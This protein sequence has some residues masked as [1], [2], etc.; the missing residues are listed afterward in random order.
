MPHT[1]ARRPPRVPRA[2]RDNTGNIPDTFMDS[3]TPMAPL[4]TNHAASR[5]PRAHSTQPVDGQQGSRTRPENVPQSAPKWHVFRSSRRLSVP[6]C[7][8]AGRA[9]SRRRSARGSR[10]AGIGSRGRRRRSRVHNYAGNVPSVIPARS[11]APDGPWVPIQ[12][13]SFFLFQIY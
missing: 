5:A 3:G 10:G 12:G 9:D 13:K 4:R 2:S 11:G 7:P 6:A 1:G 8:A